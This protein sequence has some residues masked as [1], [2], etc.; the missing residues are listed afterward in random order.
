MVR[1]G[2]WLDEAYVIS[3]TIEEKLTNLQRIQ[4]KIKEDNAVPAT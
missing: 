1:L 4:Q 2:P 3:T